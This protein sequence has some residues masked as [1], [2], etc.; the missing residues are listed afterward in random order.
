MN[1]ASF[2]ENQINEIRKKVG[3]SK[4][5][6]ALSGGVDSAAATLLVH[7][8][9]GYQLDAVFIDDGLMR[10][11]EFE[12]VSREMKKAGVNVRLVEAQ[13]E[14]FTALKRKDD[15]E[16][17][18]KA[19]RNTFYTV[20]G[21][22]VR[23]S[24]AKYLVQGTIK[25]DI[26]ET[27]GGVKTQHNVLEQIGLDP[28]GYGLNIIEPLKDFYKPEVREIAKQL[29][30]PE[31]IHQRM[32]FPGP[33]LATRVV[34]EANPER[35][36]IVRKAAA[37]V[38]EETTELKPFQAFAVLMNDKATGLEGNE[39]KFGNIIIIRCVDSEDAL[40]ASATY[41][42]WHI[43]MK[44]TERITKELPSVVRVAYEI[45]G[46]PPATIEYV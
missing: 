46:K 37:I 9:V 21:R 7:K 20:L 3:Q 19:F 24:N 18:R 2:I 12:K 15:P 11:N 5:V 25:A 28:S 38:E 36:A 34:G 23:Q 32:P 29:G 41:I 43:L 22:I 45:T 17:K 35:I 39:R 14:F 44:I 10:E 31:E 42:P 13:H 16:E 4:V 6:S 26:D 1:Y 8:A 27:K 30:L 33:G 40:T